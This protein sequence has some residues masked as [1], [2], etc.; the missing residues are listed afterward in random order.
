MMTLL[1]SAEPMLRSLFSKA[2]PSAVCK[3]TNKQTSSVGRST[4]TRNSVKY[5][6]ACL[7]R[8]QRL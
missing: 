5:A 8:L 4:Q 7:A 2:T 1:H 6:T 3:Q